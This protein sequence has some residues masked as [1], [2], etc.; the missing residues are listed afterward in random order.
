MSPLSAIAIDGAV[1]L[2][3][4]TFC[5][6]CAGALLHWLARATGIAAPNRHAVTAIAPVRSVPR[7]VKPVRPKARTLTAPCSV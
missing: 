7:R 2:S 6:S 5:E 3:L 4:L 1:A